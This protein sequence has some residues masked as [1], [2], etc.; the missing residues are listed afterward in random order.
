ML[1]ILRQIRWQ[2]ILDIALVSVILYQVFLII[3]GTRAARMLVG[4]GVLI[5][6]SVFAKYF[7]LYTMDWILQS[8]WSQVVIVLII[9]FQQEI[10]RALAQMGE[11]S[12]FQNFTSAE[13][14]KSLEEIVRAAVA[15][16]N[17]KIGALIVI[18]RDVSLKEYVEVGTPLDA[19]VNK[20]LLLSIFHPT[21]PIHDG[22]VIIRGNRVIAAGCFLPIKLGTDMSKSLGTRHRAGFG[23]TEETDAVA[24]IVSEETGHI[25][26]AM[27]GKMD[28]HVDMGTLR[29]ILTDLF[30]TKKK[31]EMPDRSP[32]KNA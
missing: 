26:L 5:L 23:L 27:N 2:D 8:F 12:F 13:E 22:A 7:Q 18:E 1:D 16:A 3:K 28:S 30:T 17:R 32:A 4:V 19:K 21:S 20:D 9:V 29:D 31:P 15:C 14:L 6:V 24:I 10:R 25:S 11:S